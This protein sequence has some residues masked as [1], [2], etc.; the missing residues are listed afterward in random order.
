VP[1]LASVVPGVLLFIAWVGLRIG[2]PTEIAPG[3]PWRSWGP[4]LSPQNL[5]WKTF[6]E[7]L[8]DLVSFP[9]GRLLPQFPILAGMLPDGADQLAVRVAFGLALAAA[10]LALWA[11]REN[12]EGP[13]ARWRIV[14]LAALALALFFL[15]P[16]DIRGYM[17]Y[18][19]TRFA[20]LAAA[21]LVASV[22][23]LD[24]RWSRRA[25]LAA[26]AVSLA[27]A[28]PLWGAF[29][30]FDQ[31]SSA[32]ESV[33]SAAADKPRVMGLIWAPGSRAV[34]HPVYLHA[35]CVVARE[36]GG[37]SNFS[38]ALTPHSPVMYRGAPPPTFDSEW[39]P[40]TFDWAR[41]G[42]AYDHFLIKGPTAE[43]LFGSRMGS[44][45]AV[46]ARAADFTLVRR[47]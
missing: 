41:Q 37:F 26:A 35:A 43:Q 8:A 30:T 7:N 27:V 9:V 29:R 20:H 12:R 6:G 24:A 44:E 45:L 46:V 31:E 10:G 34:T 2:Q 13:V 5:G 33:I 18:L 23:A 1:A 21:L 39:R 25:L 28:G 16:F 14:G 38:F 36:K 4:M 15:L 22:P 40:D 32:L 3:Q 17:Y 11:G 19:N 42:P 47:R